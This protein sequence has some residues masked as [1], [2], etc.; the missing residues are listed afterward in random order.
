MVDVRARK[1]ANEIKRSRGGREA[2]GS[3][4]RG[5]VQTQGYIGRGRGIPVHVGRDRVK[6]V[7]FPK[8][9]DFAS[10]Q[11]PG[12]LPPASAN[13]HESRSRS[14]ATYQPAG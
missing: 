5:G 2:G 1:E 12:N 9:G 10:Q 11:Q 8:G 3:G 13:D 7:P 14:S 4:G 6:L